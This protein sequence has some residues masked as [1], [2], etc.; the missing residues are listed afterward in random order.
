MHH[1]YKASNDMFKIASLLILGLVIAAPVVGQVAYSSQIQPIFNARCTNCHGLIAGVNLESYGATVSSIGAWY[2]KKIVTPG[3][4]EASPLYDKLLTTPQFGSQMPEGGSL[5][6]EQIQLIRTWI[7]EGATETPTSLEEQERPLTLK[8][9]QN[10]PN[11]FNPSTVIRWT[12]DVGRQT[13]LAVYDMMGREVA[14]LVNGLMPAGEHTVTFNATALPSGIYFYIL[15][16]GSQQL[17]RKMLLM[18]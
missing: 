12:I 13:H 5:T 6:A 18:K 10:F 11:P 9:E 4:A 7:N 8:L 14:V 2:N 17:S 16:S 15:Q 3:N 1:S